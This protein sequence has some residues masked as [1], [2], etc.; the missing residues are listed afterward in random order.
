MIGM[1]ANPVLLGQREVQLSASI[2]IAVFPEDDEDPQKLLAHADAA[3]RTAKLAGKA[4][5][6]FYSKDMDAAV[7]DLLALQSDLRLALER[8]E[9]ELHF[10]PKLAAHSGA[11]CGAEALVRWR[12]PVRGLVSPA[13]FIPAA[14]RFGLIQNIGH[15]VLDQAV[16]QAATWLAQ[17]FCVPVAVNLSVLELRQSNLVERVTEVLARHGVA[18]NML[19]LEITESAAMEDAERTLDIIRRLAGAGVK[20]AIDDFGTGYSSLSYLRRF[21]AHQIKVDRSFVTDLEVSEEARSIVTAVVQM[22]RALGLRVV[23]EGVETPRQLEDLTQIGCD[24]LQ[25]YLL[26]RPLPAD[27]FALRYR[28]GGRRFVEFGARVIEAAA[29]VAA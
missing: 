24:E 28:D 25:G 9:F 11:L 18:A 26:D 13:L 17:G 1:T 20:I 27:E 12:H 19:V 15:W 16:R 21:T 29:P 22:A 5:F 2:G 14:E 4:Q 3:L 23:A 8:D 10:Q 6:R 7:D